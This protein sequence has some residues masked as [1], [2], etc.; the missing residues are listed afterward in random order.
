M[1]WPLFAS[2]KSGFSGDQ[3]FGKT[4][5]PPSATHLNFSVTRFIKTSSKFLYV[6]EL[7][8]AEIWPFMVFHGGFS[9]FDFDFWFMKQQSSIS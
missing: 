8:V 6:A 2:S 3:F 9:I 5:P 1:Y 4:G 7:F